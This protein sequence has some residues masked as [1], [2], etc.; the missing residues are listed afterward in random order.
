MNPADTT[1]DPTASDT[2]EPLPLTLRFVLA[3]GGL[4]FVGWFIMFA[5]LQERW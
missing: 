4:I 1:T 5:V 3:L 2:D